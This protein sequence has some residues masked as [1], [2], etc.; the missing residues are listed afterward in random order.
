MNTGK[1]T[2]ESGDHKAIVNV[3]DNKVTITFE[4]EFDLTTEHLSPA[5]GFVANVTAIFM[6]GIRG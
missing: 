2:I 1:I 6:R 3:V 4:P 5:A